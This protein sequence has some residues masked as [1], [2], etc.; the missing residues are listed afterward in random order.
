MLVLGWLFINLV[1]LIDDSVGLFFWFLL[2]LIW[3]EKG[4]FSLFFFVL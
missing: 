2:K 4:F 3:L 1:V